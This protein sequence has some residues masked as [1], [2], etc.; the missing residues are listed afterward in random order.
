MAL[1]DLIGCLADSLKD[2]FRDASITSIIMPL[3][4]RKLD[5]IEDSS[6]LLIPMFECFESI[7]NSLG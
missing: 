6:M 1:L 2:K 7:T 3:L 5:T 4:I